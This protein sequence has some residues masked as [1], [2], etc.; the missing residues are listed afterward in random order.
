MGYALPVH[1]RA[2]SRE[3]RVDINLMMAG[4]SMSIEKAACMNLGLPA[5]RPE[6]LLLAFMGKKRGC[7]Q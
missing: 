7:P 4:S 2:V 5:A 3:E 1:L 6:D